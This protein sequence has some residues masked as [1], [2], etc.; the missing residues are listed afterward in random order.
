MKMKQVPGVFSIGRYDPSQSFECLTSRHFCAVTRTLKEVSVVTE[1]DLLPGGYDAREDGWACLQVDGI[2][3]FSSTG[4]L[5]Q[6][7]GALA[8]A[9]ISLFAVST[10]DTDYVLVKETTLSQA[11]SALARAGIRVEMV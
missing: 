6:I 1:S 2:L 5:S 11:K 8:S 9:E 7:S 10:F 3:D 4:I